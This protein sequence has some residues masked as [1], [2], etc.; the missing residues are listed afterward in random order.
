MAVLKGE[1]TRVTLSAPKS[2]LRELDNHLKNF[3]LTDRSR[4]ILDAVRDKLAREKI[5][6]SEIQDDQQI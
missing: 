1:V 5:M 6:L 4:W 3:A 2:L